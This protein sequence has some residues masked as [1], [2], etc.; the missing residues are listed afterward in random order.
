M[1]AGTVAIVVRSLAFAAVIGA[2]AL[3]PAPSR[4]A[5]ATA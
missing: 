2:V 5:G 1:G 3:L 4:A